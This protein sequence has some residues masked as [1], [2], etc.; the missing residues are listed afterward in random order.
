MENIKLTSR[1]ANAFNIIAL[2]FFTSSGN[3]CLTGDFI[4]KSGESPRA[5]GALAAS[6][7][8]KG[9]VK[10]DKKAGVILLTDEGASRTSIK[11]TKEEAPEAPEAPEAKTAAPKK[12]K[13]AR[14]Y[15]SEGKGD[16]GLLRYIP[17]QVRQ[18]VMGAYMDKDGIWV[19]LDPLLTPSYHDDGTLCHFGEAGMKHGKRAWFWELQGGL[20]SRDFKQDSITEEERRTRLE[21]D[22]SMMQFSVLMDMPLEAVDD[23]LEKLGGNRKAIWHEVVLPNVGHP[24]LGA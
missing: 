12:Q 19:D 4:A 3:G 16:A 17:K 24:Q 2:E 5:A 11:D 7:Q 10:I 18:Y 13:K 6:L 14:F 9:L 15:I 20:K 1:E 8:K 21:K 22:C 23:L